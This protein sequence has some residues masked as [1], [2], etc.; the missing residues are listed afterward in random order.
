MKRTCNMRFGTL[1]GCI[2]IAVC[3]LSAN[4]SA[5]YNFTTLEKRM[6][7]DGRLAASETVSRS[8]WK[9]GSFATRTI[10]TLVHPSGQEIQIE[11]RRL[12][13]LGKSQEVILHFPTKSKTTL[14]LSEETKKKYIVAFSADSCL[15][16]LEKKASEIR[17]LNRSSR[18]LF[19]FAT[20]EVERKKILKDRSVVRRQWIAPALE[21][22]VMEERVSIRLADGSSGGSSTMELIDA[23]RFP[24]QRTL[25][26]APSDF[27]ERKPSEVSNAARTLYGAPQ[28]TECQAS[29]ELQ[30]DNAY[31]LRKKK[32]N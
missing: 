14:V 21:C 12:V 16:S 6:F 27:V 23:S 31:E 5:E 7:P 20:V 15:A 9:D 13:D 32:A 1:S 28:C 8:R 26:D 22:Q 25:L 30:K 18:V 19:G 4:D 2:L 29:A 17:I 11:S 24:Q 10:R 3:T